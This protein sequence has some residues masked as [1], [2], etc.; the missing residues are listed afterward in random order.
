MIPYICLCLEI[1]KDNA[2][3]ATRYNMAL[4]SLSAENM[5]RYVKKYRDRKRF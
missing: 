5:D 1:V 2:F 3:S 4:S